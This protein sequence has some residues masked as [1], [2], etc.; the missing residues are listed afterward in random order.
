[1]SANPAKA[2]LEACEKM[3]KDWSGT[4]QGDDIEEIHMARA[5]RICVEALEK[6][7]FA[8]LQSSGTFS[9]KVVEYCQ[10]ALALAAE[11]IGK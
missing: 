2:L 3:E 4:P 7:H 1:V 10:E 9:V 8:G 5:L 6:L 11:E